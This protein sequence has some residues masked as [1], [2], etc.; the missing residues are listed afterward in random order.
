MYFLGFWGRNA[1]HR[2]LLSL[3]RPSVLGCF[4][5][6]KCFG[7]DVAVKP[8]FSGYIKPFF[9]II[10]KSLFGYHIAE[11][12][13]PSNPYHPISVFLRARKKSIWRHVLQHFSCLI[14]GGTPHFLDTN[15]GGPRHPRRPRPR[16]GWKPRWWRS[17]ASC[18]RRPDFRTVTGIVRE[19][20][21]IH[22]LYPGY[23]G[24]NGNLMKFICGLRKW[25]SDTSKNV[26]STKNDGSFSN[27]S[28][29]LKLFKV[30]NVEKR[31]WL[32]ASLKALESY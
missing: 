30:P 19:K 6:L 5:V 23:E 25:T 2:A 24:F 7:W 1:C 22:Q 9:S 3:G 18:F 16:C 28:H 26:K 8:S 15:P 32:F 29:G 13:W 11:Y 21:D 14:P 10:H 31:S 27:R 12:V 17:S 20:V 4:D